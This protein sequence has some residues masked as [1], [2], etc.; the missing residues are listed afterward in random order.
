MR[1]HGFVSV[2]GFDGGL[3]FWGNLDSFF[4][5]CCCCESVG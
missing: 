4:E 2:V 5:C 3:V 1:K